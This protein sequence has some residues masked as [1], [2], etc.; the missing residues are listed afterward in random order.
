MKSNDRAGSEANPMSGRS[1]NRRADCAGTAVWKAATCWVVLVGL[2]L[3]LCIR[4]TTNEPIED[5]AFSG[6][7]AAIGAVTRGLY[8]SPGPRDILTMAVCAF[9]LAVAGF[10]AAEKMARESYGGWRAYSC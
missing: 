5:G 7:G 6:S 4:L 1:A 3:I 9:C 2:L 8:S 10:A